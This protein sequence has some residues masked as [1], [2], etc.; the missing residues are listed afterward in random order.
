MMTQS[1]PAIGL[2]PEPSNCAGEWMLHSPINSISLDMPLAVP[3][4]G[5][6]RGNIRLSL[7]TTVPMSAGVFVEVEAWS[8]GSRL[9]AKALWNESITCMSPFSETCS[10]SPRG[11]RKLRPWVKV[12]S[13][14]N[15]INKELAR[16]RKE[17]LVGGIASDPVSRKASENAEP[18][19]R[20]SDPTQGEV[21]GNDD[22][23]PM[24]SISS[25]MYTLPFSCHIPV[26]LPFSFV[27]KTE[28]GGFYEVTYKLTAYVAGH[29]RANTIL[30]NSESI[31]ITRQ[32]GPDRSNPSSPTLGPVQLPRSPPVRIRKTTND[33]MISLHSDDEVFVGQDMTG[34][35][36]LLL[37]EPVQACRGVRLRVEGCDAS[38]FM[39]AGDRHHSV[40]H[41][42]DEIV[43]LQQIQC[44]EKQ[45]EQTFTMPPGNYKVPFTYR[46][47]SVP[48][49][50]RVGADKEFLRGVSYKISAYLDAPTTARFL[51]TSKEIQV[52]PSPSAAPLYNRPVAE[53]KFT[54]TDKKTF[55][56]GDSLGVRATI[57][58][59]HHEI[60]SDILIEVEVSNQCSKV[61]RT[62]DVM[63]VESAV[64]T[65]A[66]LVSTF[67]NMAPSERKRF[68]VAKATTTEVISPNSTEMRTCRLPVNT[69]W[70][71]ITTPN[72]LLVISHEVE[73]VITVSSKKKHTMRIPVKIYESAVQDESPEPSAQALAMRHIR[74]AS[75][76]HHRG[77]T[78][79][80]RSM[81]L[82]DLRT[83]ERTELASDHCAVLGEDDHDSDFGDDEEAIVIPQEPTKINSC[84]S[85][86]LRGRHSTK[87][88]DMEEE[89][90]DDED[91]NSDTEFCTG[92]QLQRELAAAFKRRNATQKEEQ[93]RTVPVPTRD[94]PMPTPPTRVHSNTC[95]SPLPTPP[96]TGSVSAVR[97]TPPPPSPPTTIVSVPLV[98]RSLPSSPSAASS[99]T[100]TPS[101]P[102]ATSTATTTPT[103]HRPT[104]PS[105]SLPS[106][107]AK[108][109]LPTPT[110]S[111]SAALP[112][113][114][115][116]LASL[117]DLVRDLG[118]IRRASRATNTGRPVCAM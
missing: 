14:S 78:R 59:Q 58:N 66:H 22:E 73:V 39:K 115:E 25:G 7:E 12:A 40:Q 97:P 117:R 96:A 107:P 71:T 102:L 50:F 47:Q 92:R 32:D 101:T 106:P 80:R 27:K 43:P 30:S 10:T 45:R 13:A 70:P 56:F 35:V 109:C 36:H 16:K 68:V 24:M 41:F 18:V 75:I 79:E 113:D 37:N 118:V 67:I 29:S 6:L 83:Q 60:G 53:S 64:Q 69:V 74:Q 48:P 99:P 90:S 108:R 116:D 54:I 112:T 3:R 104:P 110:P 62:I 17:S 44:P 114:D 19:H 4:G 88:T 63:L 91:D 46:F 94:R 26:D 72:S 31:I 34:Y 77:A 15:D 11:M 105:R 33:N 81:S 57:D 23:E 5:E 103:K 38:W 2:G 86:P 82:P 21:C 20:L 51:N 65:S 42:L 87:I 89:C 1:T 9:T 61:V 49:S 28:D 55:L 100:T 8:W 111:S 84:P 98:P 85:S 76:S 93:E 95:T 52:N